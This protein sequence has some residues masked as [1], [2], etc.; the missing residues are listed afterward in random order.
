VV[1]I[2]VRGPEEIRCEIRPAGSAFTLVISHSDGGIDTQDCASSEEASAR[3]RA[4]Q[5]RL[6][7]HGWRL[8]RFDPGP[9]PAV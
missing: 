8:K 2:Y 7:D 1:W 9:I 6:F 3:Q 4:L 5:Q